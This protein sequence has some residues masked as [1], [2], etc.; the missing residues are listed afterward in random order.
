MADRDLFVESAASRNLKG[1]ISACAL[2]SSF[3]MPRPPML[4]RALYMGGWRTGGLM[5]KG[6]RNLRWETW[7]WGFDQRPPF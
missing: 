4:Y 6:R 3:T 1:R 7:I 5:Q 2:L